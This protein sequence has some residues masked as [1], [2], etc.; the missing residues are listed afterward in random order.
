MTMTISEP[1]LPT[2][3]QLLNDM[4]PTLKMMS[5]KKLKK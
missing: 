3:P 2:Q 4:G 1:K 5:K